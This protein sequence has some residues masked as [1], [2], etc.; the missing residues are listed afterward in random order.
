MVEA[1]VSSL[2]KLPLPQADGGFIRLGKSGGEVVVLAALLSALWGSSLRNPWCFSPG[3]FLSSLSP[4]FFSSLCVYMEFAYL[5]LDLKV[6]GKKAHFDLELELHSSIHLYES[7]F[8]CRS[9]ATC[10]AGVMSMASGAKLLCNLLAVWP[11]AVFKPL[12]QFHHL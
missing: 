2:M 9:A 5:D 10:G 1:L 11:W 12:S 7:L 8:I 4:S 3:L 6:E